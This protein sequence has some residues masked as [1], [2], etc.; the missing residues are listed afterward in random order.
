M[1]N[2]PSKTAELPTKKTLESA[3]LEQLRLGSNPFAAQVAAVGTAEDSIQTNVPEFI[4]SQFSEL[5]DIIDTYRQDRP[6]TRVY[7]LLGDRGSGKTHLLYML[8]GEL[9]QRALQSG[10]ETMVVVVDRL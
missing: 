3:A 7:P 10:D 9:R 8:R 2:H 4:A 5:L 6:A 1:P